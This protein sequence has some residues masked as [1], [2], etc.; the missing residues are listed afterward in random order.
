MSAL[1][2]FHKWWGYVAISANAI[3]GV[4]ALIAWR[5]RKARGR[6]VWS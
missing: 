1:F 4:I 2:S 5:A 3:A 6:W